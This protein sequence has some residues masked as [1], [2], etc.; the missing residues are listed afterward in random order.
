MWVRRPSLPIPRFAGVTRTA[1]VPGT[2]PEGFR[3]SELVGAYHALGKVIE[4]KQLREAGQ[5]RE[6]YLNNPFETSPDK[7]ETDLLWRISVPSSWEP[8]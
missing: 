2:N 3:W 5:P 8:S 7:C 4:D 6:V 1:E